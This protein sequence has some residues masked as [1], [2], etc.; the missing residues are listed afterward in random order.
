MTWKEKEAR[1]FGNLKTALARSEK[2][3]I[4]CLK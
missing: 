3:A 2:S 1:F 4:T